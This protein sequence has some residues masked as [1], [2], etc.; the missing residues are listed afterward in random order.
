[1]LTLALAFALLAGITGETGCF[2]A[3]PLS[4][5]AA[6]ASFELSEGAASALR[7]YGSA[8]K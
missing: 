6:V 7:A 4:A 2:V 3:C 8:G 5:L 1:M